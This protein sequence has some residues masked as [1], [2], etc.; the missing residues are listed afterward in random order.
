M[1]EATRCINMYKADLCEFRRR[2][3][4]DTSHPARHLPV[5]QSRKGS[6]HFFMNSNVARY[7]ALSRAVPLLKTLWPRFGGGKLGIPWSFKPSVACFSVL[8]VPPFVDVELFRGSCLTV[9]QISAR[10]IWEYPAFI[11]QFS[12]YAK[13]H[14]HTRLS[15]FANYGNKIQKHPWQNVSELFSLAVSTMDIIA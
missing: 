7:R 4:R 15:S 3:C 10:E 5:P 6:V 9:T 11:Y 8:S 2:I 14:W 12:N 1:V 13:N